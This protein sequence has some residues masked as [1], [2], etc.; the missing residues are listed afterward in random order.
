MRLNLGCGQNK[1]VAPAG[2]EPWVNVDCEPSIGADVTANLCINWP[3]EDNSVTEAVFN[4]SLEHLGSWQVV[5][6]E[7]YRVCKP[8]AVVH[9]TVPSPRHDDWLNDPTHVLRVTPEFLQ[10][11]SRKNCRRFAEMKAANSPLAEYLGVDFELTKAEQVLDPA[12]NHLANDPALAELIR[13]RNNVVKE[14]RATLK[15]IKEA[16]HEGR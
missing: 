13:T 14:I 4:H 1:L 15:V 12:F 16:G 2:E 6:K 8:G 3:W 5:F 7:L 9:V 11:L 10:L